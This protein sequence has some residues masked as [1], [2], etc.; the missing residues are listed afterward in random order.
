MVFKGSAVGRRLPADGL[1][2]ALYGGTPAGR[3]LLQCEASMG[4]NHNLNYHFFFFFSKSFFFY[5][6]KKYN[7]GNPLVFPYPT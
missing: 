2:T 7:Q 5:L 1:H 6:I 3:G 4:G